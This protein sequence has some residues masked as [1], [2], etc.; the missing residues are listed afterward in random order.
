M[1]QLQKQNSIFFGVFPIGCI[2]SEDPPEN[3]SK[4][5]ICSRGVKWNTFQGGFQYENLPIQIKAR[6]IKVTVT[7]NQSTLHNK[8][9]IGLTTFPIV[10]WSHHMS[11]VPLT[12]I[13]KIYYCS[14]ISDEK[15]DNNNN[16]N[17]NTKTNSDIGMQVPISGAP[18]LCER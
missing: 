11:M 4:E 18:K 12:M 7:S 9:N 5:R 2:R 15:D 14:Q 13:I 3:F 10:A 6:G 1:R 16:N 17:D 8:Q